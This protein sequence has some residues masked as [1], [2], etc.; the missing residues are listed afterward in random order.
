[1][2]S[3]LSGAAGKCG[4]NLMGFSFFFP[5]NDNLTQS[6]LFKK[7]LFYCSGSANQIMLNQFL[8]SCCSF[9]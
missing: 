8:T 9:E 4:C 3:K 1:M 6:C 7:N 2:W 5:P